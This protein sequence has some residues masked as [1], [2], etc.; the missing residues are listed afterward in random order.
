MHTL[1]YLPKTSWCNFS[2]TT[3][4]ASNSLSMLE[5]LFWVSVRAWDTNTMGWPSCNKVPLTPLL[6]ASHSSTMGFLGLKY[7]SV[8][9][10]ATWS[11]ASL[12]AFSYVEFH[13]NLTFFLFS[14]LRVSVTSEW[15]WDIWTLI[16]A[17]P[18]E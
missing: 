2:T 13:V 12:N 5:Y 4:T 11:L 8:T 7:C 9:A 10:F 3:T 15:L 16:V 18:K 17:H 1:K 14:S 6:E